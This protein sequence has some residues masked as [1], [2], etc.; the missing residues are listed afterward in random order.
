MSKNV[1][2]FLVQACAKVKYA[3]FL[4]NLVKNTAVA[5]TGMIIM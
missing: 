4:Y 1:E 2:K 5:G 3:C